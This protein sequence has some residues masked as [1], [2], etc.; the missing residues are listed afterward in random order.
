MV[1][2][3]VPLVSGLVRVW[4]IQAL[5]YTLVT[6]GDSISS[7]VCCVCGAL[8]DDCAVS[9]AVWP[10]PVLDYYSSVCFVVG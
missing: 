6:R 10:F 1:V 9:V 2:V 8:H 5:H 7:E 4:I 3:R